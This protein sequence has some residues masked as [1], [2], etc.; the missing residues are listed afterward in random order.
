[1][2]VSIE[3]LNIPVN[4]AAEKIAEEI[5]FDSTIISAEVC[6]GAINLSYS[7]KREIRQFVVEFNSTVDEN[8]DNKLHVV[9]EIAVGQGDNNEQ[10]SGTVS[11]VIIAVLKD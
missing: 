5:Q 1:M 9:G 11:I 7:K 10:M 3:R 2:Y 6:V 4:T 8:Q